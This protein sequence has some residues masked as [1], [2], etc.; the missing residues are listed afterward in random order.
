M[1]ES[2][3]QRQTA[4]IR[5]RVAAGDPQRPGLAYAGT[6][7]PFAELHA[8]PRRLSQP[9]VRDLAWT[10]V[11]PPLLTAADTRHPLA[12]SDWASHPARLADWLRQQDAAP[13]ELAAWLAQGSDRRLGRQYERLWQFALA[14]APGVRLRAA[15]L[16]LREG[17]RTLGELD[18]LVEDAE[19]VHHLELAVKFYLGEGPAQAPRWLGPGGEDQLARK[20]AHLRQR[21]LPLSATPLA[22]ANLAALNIAPP[23]AALWLGGYLF[24]PLD[25]P[26]PWPTGALPPRQPQLWCERGQLPDGPWEVLPKGH[27]LAPAVADTPCLPL[28]DGEPIWPQLLVRRDAQGD[29]DARLFLVPCGWPIQPAANAA[30]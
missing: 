6:M 28:P 20:L 9:Q 1:G 15:N 17:E 3:W 4:L 12:A 23:Q 18:L 16:P 19:G 13:A 14:R 8:L 21:Q 30:S 11:A 24:Q 2:P 10:L 7:T 25:R 27:W 22:R 5:P 26:L 29:E